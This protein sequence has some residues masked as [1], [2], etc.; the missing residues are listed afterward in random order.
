MCNIGKVKQ[1]VANE[2]GPIVA[3]IITVVKTKVV[4]PIR[5]YVYVRRIQ[6][7]ADKERKQ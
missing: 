4:E 6:R 1:V 3:P 2:A 5:E 7:V